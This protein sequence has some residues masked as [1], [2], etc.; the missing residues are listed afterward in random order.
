M[1]TFLLL[2]LALAA[3]VTST[4]VAFMAGPTGTISPV[5]PTSL[6]TAKT[7]R[8]FASEQELRRY[9]REL[10]E[11]QKKEMGRAEDKIAG[12]ADANSAPAPAKVKAGTDAEEPETKT[13]HAGADEAG[14]VK[15]HGNNFEVL[16]LGGLSTLKTVITQLNPLP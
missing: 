16:R 7:M 1:K 15:V 13:K 2:P 9:F 11:K 8:A 4:L 6:Q 12:A 3:I 5:L 10:A 14:T